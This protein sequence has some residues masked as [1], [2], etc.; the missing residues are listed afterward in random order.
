[1]FSLV[2]S[3]TFYRLTVI[4]LWF[5]QKSKTRKDSIQ[6]K[7]QNSYYLH[8][9]SSLLR[10]HLFTIFLVAFDG[11][12]RLISFILFVL[13]FLA[14]SPF[15]FAFLGFFFLVDLLL[16]FFFGSQVYTKGIKIYYEGRIWLKNWCYRKKNCG[17]IDVYWGTLFKIHQAPQCKVWWANINYLLKKKLVKF[18]SR[19]GRLGSTKGYHSLLKYLVFFNLLSISGI[20]SLKC[21]FVPP[22]PLPTVPRPFKLLHL[23]PIQACHAMVSEAF[24]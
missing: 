24:T 9:K 20:N 17:P 5:H 14:F 21:T 15:F 10:L 6:R 18:K 19:F 11:T 22:R 1:M 23:T 2:L 8:S 4:T 3:F 16:L 13:H 7:N 12:C